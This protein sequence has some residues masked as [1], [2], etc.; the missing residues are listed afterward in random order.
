MKTDDGHSEL[1]KSLSKQKDRQRE[2]DKENLHFVHDQ[3]GTGR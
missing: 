2:R 1:Q 3:V